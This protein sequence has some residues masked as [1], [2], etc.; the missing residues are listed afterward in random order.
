[1]KRMMGI[2]AGVVLVGVMAAQAET[3]VAPAGTTN[4]PAEVKALV[5]QTMCPVMNDNA[6]NKKLFV[7][8]EGKRIYVC[9]GFCIKA[10]KKDPAKYVK[11]MEAAGITLEKAPVAAPAAK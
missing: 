1:M 8:Y 9:C 3:S 4:A 10:V 2:V 7:D 6:I 11:E 5:P